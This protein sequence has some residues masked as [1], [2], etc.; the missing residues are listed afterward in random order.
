VYLFDTEAEQV[1][2]RDVVK[3]LLSIRADGGTSIDAVIQEIS[4]LGSSYIHII[5]SDGITEAS[6]ELLRRFE[7]LGLAERTRLIL[8]PPAGDEDYNWVQL[9]RN[10]GRVYKA[11]DVASF[12]EA[13]KAALA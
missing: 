3:T 5:I 8:I 2:P 10:R 4:R 7:A 6:D 13:A 11:E 1:K 12:T 9:L